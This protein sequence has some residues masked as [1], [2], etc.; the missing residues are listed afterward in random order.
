MIQATNGTILVN[1]DPSDK[2]LDDIPTRIF[3]NQEETK[4]FV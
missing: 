3:S 4:A 1:S 2:D